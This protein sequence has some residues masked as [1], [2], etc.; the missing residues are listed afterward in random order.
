MPRPRVSLIFTVRNEEEALPAL[1]T[2]L[3]KQIRPPD[4]IV[5]ADGGSSDGTVP[6][7]R[8]FA[9]DQ[10]RSVIPAQ[11][12]PRTRYGVS[13]RYGAGIQPRVV[14]LELP[15]ANIAEGRNAAIGAA[16]GDIIAVTDAGVSLPRYWLAE[17]VRPLEDRPEVDMV[18]GYSRPDPHTRF[19]ELLAAAT[20]PLVSEVREASYLASSRSVAFRRELWEKA[21]GY[22]EWLDYCE[23]VVFDLE[24]KKV[25]ARVV[26]QPAASVRFRPRPHLWAFFLQYYRYARGD[27]KANLW[28]ERHV[29][30]YTAYTLGTVLL[31]RGKQN[32]LWWVMLSLAAV[33]ASRKPLLRVLTE[34]APRDKKSLIASLS[35]ILFIRVVGDIAKMLGY[36]VGVWWRLCRRQRNQ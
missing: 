36:P 16:T 1:L 15:E 20:L 11:S 35:S 24:C 18:S 29:L 7:L 21:G 8:A 34:P 10:Q 13:T 23:D 22:P 12:L 27:G 28:P 6:L 3:E 14:L 17:L 5:I 19:E 30:R 2:P 32:P 4:E 9:A 26:F 31:W 33:A 25:G